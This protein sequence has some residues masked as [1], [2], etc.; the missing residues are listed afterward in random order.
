M[1]ADIHGHQRKVGRS[2]IR[3]VRRLDGDTGISI[4]KGKTLPFAVTREWNAPA[5]HYLEQWFLIDPETK[6]VLYESA[7][8][9]VEIWGLQSLTALATEVSEPIGLE[10]GTYAV[11][12]SLAGIKGGELEFEASEAAAEAA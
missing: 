11:V 9:E 5:G 4:R 7:T 6:E 10:P 12:F 3:P 8:A 1:E 2:S